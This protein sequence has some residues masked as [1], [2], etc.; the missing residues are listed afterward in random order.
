MVNWILP[1]VRLTEEETIQRAGLDGYM[2][3]CLAKL[4]IVAFSS[5]SIVGLVVI[6]PVDYSAGNN[7]TGMDQFSFANVPVQD[8]RVWC[9]FFF[10]YLFSF[11][12]FFLL[13][14]FY[15]KVLAPLKPL[16]PLKHPLKH[17]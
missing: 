7:M 14:L 6:L 1:L 2:V 4:G 9:H 15:K 13:H 17:P 10:T 5:A 11:G 8:P 16:K 3:L 12:C